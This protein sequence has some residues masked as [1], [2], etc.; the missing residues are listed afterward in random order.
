MCSPIHRAT[1]VDVQIAHCNKGGVTVPQIISEAQRVG[2]G[3]GRAGGRGIVH[4][5][6][7]LMLYCWRDGWVL[8]ALGVVGGQSPWNRLSGVRFSC[9]TRMTCWKEVI[10]A[11]AG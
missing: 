6:R 9:T 2:V 8:H 7:C 1:A 4:P 5:P 11:E 3:I 10:W